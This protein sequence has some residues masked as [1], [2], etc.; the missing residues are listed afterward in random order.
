MSLRWGLKMRCISEADLSAYA[1][2]EV[3]AEEKA[4][5]EAHLSE[6]AECRKMLARVKKTSEFLKAGIKSTAQE[7]DALTPATSR[8]LAKISGVRPGALIRR[9]ILS[10]PLAVAAAMLIIISVFSVGFLVGRHFILREKL[11]EVKIGRDVE[12]TLP[13]RPQPGIPFEP[14][15][16]PRVLYVGIIDAARYDEGARMLLILEFDLPQDFFEP[17][18]ETLEE[19]GEFLIFTGLGKDRSF[20][21]LEE[22]MRSFEL[23]ESGE[24]G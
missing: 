7:A 23:E 24:E 1:D 8:I 2:G 16:E 20:A 19:K 15:G 22:I 12:V 3:N 13:A 4:R 9:R 6:C 5:I 18:K 10:R 17:E 14:F 21:T 11:V